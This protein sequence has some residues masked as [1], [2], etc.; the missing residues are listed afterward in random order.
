MTSH[1]EREVEQLCQ[2]IQNTPVD[3][4]T[5]R[6]E[7]LMQLKVNGVRWRQTIEPADR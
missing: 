5:V 7:T 4:W 6:N 2:R 3:S 1:F